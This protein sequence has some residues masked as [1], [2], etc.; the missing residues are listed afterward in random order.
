MYSFLEN[1][2]ANRKRIYE[3]YAGMFPTFES[4]CQVMDQCTENYECLV[5][6]N[7]SKSNQ[8][9]DQVFWYKAD[10]HGDFRLGSKEFWELSKNIGSDDEEEK[11]DPN[12]MKKK[13]AGPKISV[14]KT[15]KW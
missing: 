5:I 2:I 7:N 6:N 3:N 9:R 11:Y 12:S 1:Y 4:F 13:G 10:S 15:T 14:K 8:L